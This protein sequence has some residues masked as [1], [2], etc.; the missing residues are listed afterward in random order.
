MLVQA[1]QADPREEDSQRLPEELARRQALRKKME[2]ACA[3][4]EARAQARAE[5][6][7]AQARRPQAQPQPREGHAQ[8]PSSKPPPAAP[9]PEAQV[10]LTDP[11]LRLMRKNRRES[12]SQGYNAQ[13]VVDAEGSP[14]I[15][16]QRV[17]DSATDAG[18]WEPGLQSI[19]QELG[20]PTAVLADCGYGSKEDFQRL[21]RQ[22]PGL[23]LYGSVHRAEAHAPRR[24]DDRPL[25]KVRSPRRLRDPVWVA[26]AEKLKTPEGRALD[27]RRLC[28]VEPAFGV[29]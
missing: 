19:P 27:R 23:A 8:G 13:V 21:G 22:R 10:H 5:A 20:Q 25:D 14:W 28:T 16:G 3:R 7:K 26:M 29:I 1:E 24:Y 6:E 18:H 15:V 2:E 12:Y 17:S 9:A 4:R 11:D